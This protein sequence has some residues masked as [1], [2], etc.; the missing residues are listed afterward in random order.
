MFIRRPMYSTTGFR[1]AFDEL[2][3]MRQNM[4]RLMEGLGSRS[5]LPQTAGVF[6]LV[7]LTEDPDG[8]YVRAELPG[9]K[10]DELDISVTGNTLSISGERKIFN[11]GENVRYHRRE[12]EAGTFN[13]VMSLP[14]EVDADK[15]E[16]EL[17][18]GILKIHLP[19]AEK[20]RPKQITVR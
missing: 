13:R 6:P 9:L 4:D 12:R 20:A 3:R 11:E 1:S 8:Y 16:A 17:K 2:D 10:A 15:V 7:N 5:F 19:K 18:N 14:G